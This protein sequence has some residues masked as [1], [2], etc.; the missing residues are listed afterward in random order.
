MTISADGVISWTKPVAGT[1]NV[2]V[3]ADNG[4]AYA[5]QRYQLTVGQQVPLDANLKITPQVINLGETVTIDVLSTGGS[6]NVTRNLTIDGQDV[7][8]TVE[9]RAIV[10]G[11]AIGA[12]QIT[13]TITDSVGTTT[14]VG[15][16]SV[17]DPADSTTPVA[18]ITAPVDDAEVTA[19]VNVTGTA[20]ATNL[21]YYQ[22][23]L[24]PA[25]GSAWSEIARGTTAVTNG[26]LGK[27]D[28]TQLA[29]GIYELVLNVVDA[30]GRQQMHLITLDIYR[31]LKV[32]QFSLSFRDLAVETSGIP[33]L[34][35][36]TYDTR[37]KGD[38]LDFGYGWSVDYQNLQLRKNMVLGLDWNVVAHPW[39]LTLCLIPAGKRKINITLPDG[40][41]ERFT[42]ANAQ[43]CAPVQVPLPDV[44]LTALP[45]TTS[46]LEIVNVPNLMVQGGV[47]YDMDNLEIWNPREFKLTTPENY[48]YYVT[49]GIGITM[50]RDPSGN[51]LT[52]GRNGIMH[53][54][55]MSV[56]FMRDA[57]GRITK[58]SDPS[59]KN[60]LYGYN[61]AGDLVSV[62]NRSGA[63]SKYNYNRSHG[64]TDYTDPMGTVAARYVY[65]DNGRVIAVYDAEGKAVEMNHDLDN[66]REMVK[67]RLGNIT[68]YSYDNSGNVVEVIDALGNK[69]SYGYDTLGNESTVT[70]ALGQTISRTYDPKSS[71]QL[72]EKDSL[73]NTRS[74]EYDTGTGTI[75]QSATDPR[76]N[77]ATFVYG[78]KGQ[79]IFEQGRNLHI[80]VD[81]SGNL[82][83]VSVSGISTVYGYDSKGNRTRQTDAAGNMTT[84]T[85]DANNREIGRSWTR[86][87]P[88]T[89]TPVA[90]STSSKL[91]A[92]GRVVELIDALGNVTKT[93]YNA[94]GQ[95]TANID[96]LG[97]KTS[98]EYSPRGKL[99]K[100]TY[101]DGTSEATDFD[102][103]SNAIARTDRQGR[104]S[105]YEYDAL[106]RLTKTIAPDGSST[107][108][109]YDAVGRV[110]A[111]VDGNGNRST[112]AYDAAGR[113]ISTTDASGRVAQ[114]GYDANGNRTTA[115]DGLG[116]ITKFEHDALNRLVKVT[117]PDGTFSTYEWNPGGTKAA[118]VD[119]SGNRT[120]YGYDRMSRLTQ[121]T[122]TIGTTHQVTIYGFDSVGNMTSQQDAEGR[123]T[124]W[125]YDAHHRVTAR[126]LPA[127]QRETF[128]YDAAG[129]RIGYTD[130]NGNSTA[131]VYDASDRPIL[132]VRQDGGRIAF[133]YT[134]T[135]MP[136]TVTVTG[137][138]KSGLQLGT[139]SYEYDAL[140]RVTRQINPDGH[141]LA[142]AY[143]N[144]GNVIER[145]TKSGTVR[146]AYDDAGRLSGVTDSEGKKTVYV[147][148]EAGRLATVATPNG[149]AGTRSYDE[150]GRLLQILYLHRDGSVVTGVR[151]GLAANG[152]RTSMLEFDSASTII[153]GVP[154]N[155]VRTRDYQYDGVRRLTREK[156]RDRSG[157]E[158]RTTDYTFDRV[159]NRKTKTEVTQAGTAITSYTYDEND[160]LKQESISTSTGS[161]VLIAYGWDNNGNL[162]SKSVGNITTFFGWDAENRLI[163]VAQ[164]VSADTATLVASYTYDAQGNRVSR[165][166]SGTT[167]SYL[168]DPT[169]D[170]ARVVEEVNSDQPAE[171]ARYTWGLNLINQSHGSQVM[172]Y[173]QD[174]L[175]STKVQTD[176]A[177]M[178]HNPRSYDAFGSAESEHIQAAIEFSGEYFD[179][180]IG[181]QYNRARWLDLSTGRFV[182]QD[183]YQGAPSAPVTL[184]KFLYADADPVNKTDPSGAFSITEQS[185]TLFAA[186]I[187]S[188]SSAPGYAA[189]TVPLLGRF[190][191]YIAGSTLGTYFVVDLA[192]KA[193][194]QECMDA[195]ARGE[196]KCRP[197]YS[198]FVLGDN[199]PSVR[200][201]VGDAI[202]TNLSPSLLNRRLP[203]GRGWLNAYKGPGKPCS[204]GPGTQCDEYPF[205]A[206]MQGY[207]NSVVGI[208]GISLRSVPAGENS[209]AG[210]KL[211]AFYSSCRIPTG[212]AYKVI[213]IKGVPSGWVCQ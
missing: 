43:E 153:G 101:P 162:T 87:V 207:P 75:L 155:P 3:R 56:A 62:T 189:L 157:N 81:V 84:Y 161:Q 126:V 181:L 118:E 61:A 180:K 176:G 90:E 197:S 96:S 65:D 194:I 15:T 211:G 108:L 40:K 17:R 177:G 76:G 70:N 143:D 2:T 51:T 120:A 210:G 140:D 72:S 164:G 31:D 159:G 100:T 130:F 115:I 54:N 29:N 187:L 45:G 138:P 204:G 139:T 133:T 132:V 88:G 111:T 172:Y 79:T 57:Q 68:T 30:N 212:G 28:P 135:G 117:A 149:V 165:T 105:R 92:E 94:G 141:I 99:A 145:T 19:P 38:K 36:R 113:I 151:Y 114:F 102:A 168:V 78:E 41:V 46:T 178:P 7:A 11:T 179:D 13:A 134:E 21:A 184:N 64:L 22:L 200:D 109:E 208:G 63:V 10:T 128:R 32:G 166:V 91:D 203:G 58:V 158:V 107:L 160:R 119:S 163:K 8:L 67:D 169:F 173:H 209:G 44:R 199:Y 110:T 52:Y 48:V 182:S 66:H 129:R 77:K 27:L 14:R 74:W 24:R 103:N 39:D 20:T 37:K 59:G 205:N 73:G 23:L 127:G 148:D 55:G 191:L 195:S 82:S 60:I 201:H 121:V 69:T 47:L 131:T 122:Q 190:A 112:M 16:Y 97:R 71:K 93:E 186:D 89:S 185:A 4:R 124:R 183:Q 198:I 202:G 167:T 123:V 49:E 146:Y 170:Y 26:V 18:Q 6:G 34:V 154:S 98:Y 137:D 106:N 136:R 33:V 95:V 192:M 12:H 25:G 196:N 150:N 125:E 80:G 174:G 213:P 147:Y 42:A 1:W 144:N 206:S 83:S 188:A 50:V 193:K 175:S 156:V 9:G 171:I 116:K 104:T 53:S 35:T 142:W 86:E 152:Q 85:F 5:E